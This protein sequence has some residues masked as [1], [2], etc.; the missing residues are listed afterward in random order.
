MNWVDL[1]VVLLIVF[2][3]IAGARKGMIIALASFAGIFLGAVVGLRLAPALTG[4]LEVDSTRTVAS[5][6]IVLLFIAL[7]EATGLWLGREIRIRVTNPSLTGVDTVL[8]S[9]VQAVAVCVVTWMIA[10]PLTG[11]K[12][13]PEVASGVTNSTT[14]RTINS[15]MPASAQALPN[16]LRRVLGVP[17]LPT[18][19]E[20]FTQTP[21]AAIDPPDTALAQSPA[22]NRARSSV[23]K[24][25]GRASACS[26]MLEGTGFVIAPQRVMTNAHVVAGT[27]R[28]TVE[29]TQGTLTARVVHFDPASDLAVLAVPSMDNDTPVMRWAPEPVS[30]G[31]DVVALGYPLDGPYTASPGRIRERIRLRGPDIYDSSTVVRDVYTVRAIIRSGNSGGPLITPNGSVAGVVFGAS[32]DN[33]E[34]GFVMTAEEASDEVQAAPRM[35]QAVDTGECSG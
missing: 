30:Q 8:G 23:L 9:V 2:G 19:L 32:V 11:A 34:T 5:L 33:P 31:E 10:L 1:V 14:L 24:I 18:A 16:E 27:D 6:A 25:R 15:L 13:M 35:S 28:V 20:P 29:S 17:G 4:W 7:G 26:R 21:V 3:A 22:V 12:S